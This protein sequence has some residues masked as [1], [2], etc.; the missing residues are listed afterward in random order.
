M[1][2][3]PIEKMNKESLDKV[4][5]TIDDLDKKHK[6]FLR[7]RWMSVLLLWEK[8]ARQA[9]FRYHLI[10]V[11]VIIS[12]VLITGI[13]GLGE[14][15]QIQPQLDEGGRIVIEKNMTSNSITVLY[16]S[17]I[18]AIQ[19]AITPN[20]VIVLLGIIVSVGTGVEG[21]FQFGQVWRK[22]RKYSELLKLEGWRFIQLSD[23]YSGKN[24]DE[25]YTEFA[26]RVEK[27]IEIELEDYLGV[28]QGSELK[29]TE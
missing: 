15:S 5:D 10:R 26:S 14:T 16:E 23:Q 8:H 24:H 27:L 12:G 13:A 22:K 2:D 11:M 21:L 17:G 3:D 29:K 28:F 1:A 7:S 4:I 25:A 20:L 18:N 9:A 6:I 19:K